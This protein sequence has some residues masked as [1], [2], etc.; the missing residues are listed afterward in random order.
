M[1]EMSL[2][3]SSLAVP[4]VRQSDDAV[5]AAIGAVIPDLKRSGPRLLGALQVAARGIGRLL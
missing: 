4:V 1:E 5:V 3:A 2:G